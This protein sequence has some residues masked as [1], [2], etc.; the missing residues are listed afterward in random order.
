MNASIKVTLPSPH[1]GQVL[2]GAEAGGAGGSAARGGGGRGGG[3]RLDAH[4]P[5]QRARVRVR[6]GAHRQ[7]HGAARR[8]TGL[9]PGRHGHREC[10]PK[11]HKRVHLNPDISILYRTDGDGG[12]VLKLSQIKK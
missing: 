12:S 9:H 5:A 8:P 3:A 11:Y 7:R 2:S 1:T 10:A 6:R 4:V